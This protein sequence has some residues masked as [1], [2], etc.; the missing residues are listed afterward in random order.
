VATD[1]RAR[2]GVPDRWLLPPPPREPELA[3]RWHTASFEQR[4]SLARTGPGDLDAL[5]PEDAE[6]VAGLARARL[7]TSWRLLATGPVLGW[8][9]LMT[10]WGFGRSTTSTEGAG[11]WL[12]AGLALGALAWFVASLAAARRL[13]RARQLLAAG[14]PPGDA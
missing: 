10:V 7:R 14:G 1:P 5:A 9:V 6:V 12:L 8:L 11:P 2:R 3:E 13:R 4:R